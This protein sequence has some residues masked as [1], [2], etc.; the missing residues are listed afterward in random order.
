MACLIS[1]CETKLENEIKMWGEGINKDK[2]SEWTVI[3]AVG[4]DR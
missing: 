4:E 1:Q 2:T 3:G